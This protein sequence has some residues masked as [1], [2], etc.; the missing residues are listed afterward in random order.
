MGN[1]FPILSS[2]KDGEREKGESIREDIITKQ[3]KET[4]PQQQH[5]RG[6][7]LPARTKSHF[8]DPKKYTTISVLVEETESLLALCNLLFRQ[9]LHHPSLLFPSRSSSSSSAPSFLALCLSDLVIA[10]Q[11]SRPN[12]NPKYSSL[13]TRPR[14]S[15]NATKTQKR[16]NRL[17]LP[18]ASLETRNHESLDKKK[19]SQHSTNRSDQRRQQRKK[20]LRKAV[21]KQKPAPKTTTTSS[22]FIGLFQNLADLSRDPRVG[23]QG[24]PTT[25]I[26]DRLHE[27][28]TKKP[29]T[30]I[31][32]SSKNHAEVGLEFEQKQCG[33]RK[34]GPTFRRLLPQLL[35]MAHMPLC[36][37]V[38]LSLRFC[39]SLCPFLFVGFLCT[40]FL[41]RKALQPCGEL[42]EQQILLH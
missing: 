30:H 24:S 2:Q 37:C 22:R 28:K 13:S 39:V 16:K 3:K 19:E 38:S 31:P 20:T 4:K 9:L 21:E 25:V 14:Q 26:A 29:P 10:S 36:V 34:V 12:T 23:L 15:Q 35:F 40:C 42:Q 7:S 32:E 18:K 11:A 27:Q 5:N 6:L 1:L 33:T 41:Y 17:G 8:S